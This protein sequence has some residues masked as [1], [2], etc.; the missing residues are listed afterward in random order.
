MKTN[1]NIDFDFTIQYKV[2]DIDDLENLSNF[3]ILENLL[4]SKLIPDIGSTPKDVSD[5]NDNHDA[6]AMS[7]ATDNLRSVIG[8]RMAIQLFLSLTWMLKGLC[9]QLVELQMK[10]F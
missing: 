4:T 7:R 2:K 9:K 10:T 3:D 5:I 1:F 8:Q 6:D